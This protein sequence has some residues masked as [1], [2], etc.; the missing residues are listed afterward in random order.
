[1]RLHGSNTIGSEL[2]PSLVE[3][4]YRQRG[5]SDVAKRAGVG[6]PSVV[7]HATPSGGGAPELAEIS[8][9]GTATGFDALG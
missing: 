8:A 2:A 9:E 1:L 5:S 3:A 7:V 6:A 4:F